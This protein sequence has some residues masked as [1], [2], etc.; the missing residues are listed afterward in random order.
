MLNI[1][2]DVEI[3]KVKNQKDIN[4]LNLP[5]TLMYLCHSKI[6]EDIVKYIHNLVFVQE[7]IITE[8]C[9]IRLLNLIYEAFVK[10]FECKYYNIN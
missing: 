8:L 9:L 5:D 3:V 6:D 2:F 1:S 7:F 4:N 10:N